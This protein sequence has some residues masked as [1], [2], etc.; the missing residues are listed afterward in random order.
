MDH[1]SEGIW[2]KGQVDGSRL[3]LGH[4]EELFPCTL[5]EVPDGLFCNAVLEVGVDPTKGEP[6]PL[7]TAA[8]LEGVVCK[9]SIVA[10]VVEDAD[11]VM[12]GK[13]LKGLFGF[14]RLFGGKIGHEV[15]VLQP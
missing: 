9:S 14:H 13:V 11:A 4:M 1:A 15:D 5:T 12:L 6:L 7:G 10:M 3:L 2:P 8:V